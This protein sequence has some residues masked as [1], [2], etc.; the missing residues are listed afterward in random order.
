MLWV[1]CN[2]QEATPWS[3]CLHSRIP[4]HPDAVAAATAA[5]LLARSAAYLTQH[6][7]SV[8]VGR[9]ARFGV[10]SES[11]SPAAKATSAALLSWRAAAFRA[12]SYAKK[13]FLS[14]WNLPS[15]RTG[16]R[17]DVPA[18]GPSTAGMTMTPIP[19]IHRWDLPPSAD[20]CEMKR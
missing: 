6:C 14:G 20:S 7:L 17:L 10:G 2:M 5:A 9:H 15:L 4:V 19:S 13:S 3:F 12:A 11:I 1:H 8:L 18:G 16:V